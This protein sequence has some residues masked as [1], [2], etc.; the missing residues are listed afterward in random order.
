MGCELKHR[1]EEFEGDC[2]SQ[3]FLNYV[4]KNGPHAN[5]KFDGR[6]FIV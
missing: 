2:H 3:V 6:D 4:K 5:Q 1:R